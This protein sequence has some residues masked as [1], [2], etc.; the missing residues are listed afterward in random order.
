MPVSLAYRRVKSTSARSV[1]AVLA[2]TA[3]ALGACASAEDPP[4]TAP[5]PSAD[6]RWA[7]VE[8]LT[9]CAEKEGTVNVDWI[10]IP[11]E[12]NRLIADFKADYPAVDLKF[13]RDDSGPLRALQEQELNAGKVNFDVTMSANPIHYMDWA[14]DGVIEKVTDLPGYNELPEG[15]TRDHGSTVALYTSINPPLINTKVIPLDQAP[16]SFEDMTDARFKGKIGV[17]DPTV[18]GTAA[19]NWTNL[20]LKYGEEYIKKIAAQD[21]KLY[22]TVVDG[23]A[24]A[25]AAGEIGLFYAV[26][27]GAMM[28]TIKAAGDAIK[29][30]PV[31]D[32]SQTT[33]ELAIP[34]GAAHPC[35]ARLFLHWATTSERAGAQLKTAGKFTAVTLKGVNDYGEIFPLYKG[36]T[37]AMVI[38]P[39]YQAI[40]DFQD[41]DGLQT[42]SDILGY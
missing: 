38:K 9:S 27:G 28:S 25:L 1:T 10:L 6:A 4:E 42:I 23:S 41:D 16:K 33:V 11:D 8:S 29:V 36:I 7:T 14:E 3:L 2:L 22:R 20:Y 21:P 26:S 37:T 15:W 34:K 5:Q 24:G 30:V 39:D 17:D 13:R 18:S 19:T 12:M 35:A 40:R 32:I 31:N